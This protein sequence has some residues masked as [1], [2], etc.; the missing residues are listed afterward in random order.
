[1]SDKLNS[2][3]ID[4]V[5]TI[6]ESVSNH[7]T[8]ISL[9]DLAKNTKIAKT[10]VFRILETL[11][12]REYVTLDNL[13]ERYILDI[14]SLELGIKGLMNVNLVEVA[15]PYLKKLSSLTQE[16]CFLGVYNHGHV[17]YLYKSEGTLAIQTNA[18]LGSRMPAYCTGI[19]K[20]L[21]AHQSQEEIDLQ[22]KEPLVKYTE[23][24]IT[25]RVGLYE[26]LADIRLK[27]YSFDNEENEEGLTCVAKPIFNYTGNVIG[28]ISVAGP[29]NRMKPKLEQVIEDL[30]NVSQVVSRRLGHIE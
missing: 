3:S 18:H 13:T 14:K 9:A 12:L 24:T 23:N 19:G 11:K 6:L 21:L 8:G 10:T 25:D 15:I 20:A 1:M 26:A 27:G 4:K 5:L 7:P 28:A 2:S 16:T 29:T 30:K 22:L 17:V